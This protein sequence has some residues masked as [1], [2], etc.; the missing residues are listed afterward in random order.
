MK[1]MEDKDIVGFLES[2]KNIPPPADFTEEVMNKLPDGI[3]QQ[4]NWHKKIYDFFFAPKILRWNIATAMV[5]FLV[6]VTIGLV[7]IQIERNDASPPLYQ[8][9]EKGTVPV[10]FSIYIPDAK[11]VSIVG[12]FNN[13]QAEEINLKD[14]EINDIW[15]VEIY[16]KP[17]RYNYMFLVDGQRWITDPDADTIIDDGFGNKNAVIKVGAI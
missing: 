9:A 11:S 4:R 6:I 15:T 13:W 7:W 5:S 1:N 3:Y 14:R 16:L 2:V 10:R 17:G 12:D 8:T